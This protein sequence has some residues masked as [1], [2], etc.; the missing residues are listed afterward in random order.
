MTTHLVWFRADLRLHDNIALAA[1]CRSQ[2]ARVLALFIATPEQWREHGMAPRQA[3]YLRAHLN[4][5]QQGLAEKGIP[6][7]YEEVSDFA[8]QIDK[9]QQVCDAHNVTHLFYNYQY[10]FNEQ[11][12]DRQL[13]NRLTTVVCQGFDD[14][15]MLAPGSVMTG[16]HEMYKV[17]TP[18]KN[19]YLKRLKEG[20]PECVAAPAARGEALTVSAEISVDYPQR[21]FDP[22]HFPPTEK[23]AIAQLRQFCKQQAAEYEAQRDFP[24][25]EGTSRLSACLAL[26]VLSPRQCLHRLLAEQPQALDG[27]PGAVWLNELIWREFYRHLMT[28]HPD[29]CKHRPFIRWTDKVQWQQ[30]D[31]QLQAWQNGQTGY[32]IVDA[33]M[34][35]L[36]E[37]GWMHNR[38]RM[39]VASFLVK[40]LLI[41]WRAGE[42]YFISQ[43]IDGDLAANNGGWQWAA[44]TGTDAAPYFRI[45]NPTTQGQRFDATGE[46]IRQWL[47][48]LADVPGKSIHE[49]W[50]WAD[51]TGETLDYPRPIVDHK[52]ARVATLA[53]YE[54][55][56]KA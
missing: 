26:G 32:P 7:I 6:L 16:N 34:R 17:F 11:K 55:A 35:Q 8:A 4:A 19:A 29:L 37:T 38:L 30:D 41:D 13:E 36:N 40:D 51:K 39:I 1:A 23:A 48:E 53:A 43:L 22:D 52:Q 47:P 12:R 24:A 50:V 33:A 9:V 3:A 25:I 2:D 54:A 28:Y 45:F 15:V 49:P 5:L 56:R 18:F 10:E 31:A 20:L 46:F 27:G 42:R 14:S 44:S 21:D